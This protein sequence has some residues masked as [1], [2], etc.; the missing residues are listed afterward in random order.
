MNKKVSEIVLDAITK[1]VTELG[2]QIVDVIYE[3]KPTGMNLTVT[4]DSK[5]GISLDDCERVHHLIDPILD[6]VDPTN[7]ASYILNVSSPGLDRP[8]KTDEDLARNIDEVVECNVFVKVEK[9]KTLIGK[10]VSFNAELVT[11]DCSGKMVDIL[12]SNISKLTKFIEI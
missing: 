9:L 4:I 7:G 6:E 5:A 3:K 10:L 1:P 12:R 11:L 2:Y 8:I